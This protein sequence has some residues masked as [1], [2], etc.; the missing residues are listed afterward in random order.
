MSPDSPGIEGLE[1]EG[2]EELGFW[3]T[4]GGYGEPVSR[5]H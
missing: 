5:I 2:G 1:C 4:R 3:A